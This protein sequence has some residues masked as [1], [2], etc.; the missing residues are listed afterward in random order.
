[1]KKIVLLSIALFSLS[2]CELNKVN[3][4]NSVAKNEL[5]I[6][7]NVYT[8]LK[9]NV[10]LSINLGKEPAF[11]TK[12][13]DRYSISKVDIRIITTQNDFF[14]AKDQIISLG[15]NNLSLDIPVG[16]NIVIFYFKDN[17]D[18]IL[19][20]MG[21]VVN[22]VNAQSTNLILDDNS[23]YQAQI[24]KMLIDKGKKD[25]ADK[26]NLD[27]SNDLFP[28]FFDINSER[29]VK[30]LIDWNNNNPNKDINLIKKTEINSYLKND[31][32]I[33]QNTSIKIKVK[34]KN[35]KNICGAIIFSDTSLGNQLITDSL[36]EVSFNNLLPTT[37]FNKNY[38]F[39]VSYGAIKEIYIA[40]DKNNI[41]IQKEIVLP[42]ELDKESCDGNNIINNK[43]NYTESIIYDS[44]YIR[45]NIDV[46][47][48]VI[49]L[50]E[51]SSNYPILTTYDE[52]GN[53]YIVENNK[54]RRI[55]AITKK[56]TTIFG[57]N[58]SNMTNII[59]Q[60]AT[61][62]Q[63]NG[64]KSILSNRKGILLVIDYDGRVRTIDLKNNLAI[65][66]D[67]INKDISSLSLNYDENGNFYITTQLSPD[68]I[69]SVNKLS[70]NLTNG[71]V[72]NSST[73]GFKIDGSI[74][75][76]SGKLFLDK[77]NN[78][79]MFFKHA[80]KSG[81]FLEKVNISSLPDVIYA[82]QTNIPK[83][84]LFD[85]QD[86]NFDL[87]NNQQNI[88][89]DQKDK[90]YFSNY[91]QNKSLF[92][93]YQFNLLTNKMN[94][95]NPNL[96]INLPNK[97]NN[98]LNSFIEAGNS[99]QDQISLFLGLADNTENFFTQI[100]NYSIVDK[101][102]KDVFGSYLMDNIKEGV[103]LSDLYSIPNIYL[104]ND[105]NGNFYVLF[106]NK[107]LFIDKD[108][109]IVNKILSLPF[110]IS[111]KSENTY[112]TAI[113]NKNNFFYLDNSASILY[114]T[115]LKTGET[116][117]EYLSEYKNRPINPILFI[118]LDNENNLNGIS[119]NTDSSIYTIDITGKTLNKKY[120]KI[121]S[122]ITIG[123][124]SGIDK[125]LNAY[126]NSRDF[127]KLNLISGKKDIYPNSYIDKN[128]NFDNVLF[129][130]FIYSSYNYLF[131]KQ[132]NLYYSNGN[133][134]KKV[135]NLTGIVKNIWTSQ[136]K[137]NNN[138]YQNDSFRSI[139]LG[140]NGV[141]YT[142]SENQIIKI[143]PN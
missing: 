31:P 6:N 28:F 93:L 87:S 128:N 65:D 81:A 70:I 48:D 29:I 140:A 126:F 125:N 14:Y 13:F 119:S 30:F 7:S 137:S 15:A 108:T 110:S 139:S 91:D 86:T 50:I 36:G 18:V 78:L 60:D 1:M 12:A 82:S 84:I 75:A 63:S 33:L 53:L 9:G 21:G 56:I 95:I 135:D 58:P 2:A 72:S 115:D 59:I 130:D 54:I 99:N 37:I 8:G 35:N 4:L 77:N 47:K 123:T 122:E 96:Q 11:K 83:Q 42:I 52:N 94:L 132:N 17:N 20:T 46:K 143:S 71:D 106:R 104:K 124:F 38:Y 107:I 5:K 64:I 34:D 16:K 67:K 103:K 133:T 24:I 45:E 66:F 113:D 100:I 114:K 76:I 19:K 129:Y 80:N 105:L 62:S 69:V 136:N 73:Q 118:F 127:V 39:K 51:S 74:Q 101:S 79:N 90:L 131:D 68:M 88:S 138:N 44:K 111:I 98:I 27:Q 3:N 92:K 102:I 57:K 55:D 49:P 109:N 89:F 61:N 116:T 43:V 10:K 117:T 120:K 41:N 97:N 25:L 32:S 85:F 26:I 141:V 112:N 22:I 134:I 23:I 121:S 142:A 40:Y